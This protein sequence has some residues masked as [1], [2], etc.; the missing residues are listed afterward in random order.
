MVNFITK[1]TKSFFFSNYSGA[2]STHTNAETSL[3]ST[4]CLFLIQDGRHHG[5]AI[6]RKKGYTPCTS[7]LLQFENNLLCVYQDLRYEKE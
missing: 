3:K 6:F 4:L 2:S 7:S 1:Y 5:N